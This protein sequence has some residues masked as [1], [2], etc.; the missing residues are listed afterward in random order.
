MK[1]ICLDDLITFINFINN[2]EDVLWK[3][4]INPFCLTDLVN[5]GINQKK[6]RTLQLEDP[7]NSLSSTP[8]YLEERVKKLEEAVWPKNIDYGS[9][10]YSHSNSMATA[11]KEIDFESRGEAIHTLER[12]R[13]KIQKFGYITIANYYYI[14]GKPEYI[15]YKLFDYGWTNLNNV[16]VYSYLKKG[17]SRVYCLTLPDP[18]PIVKLD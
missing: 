1:Y 10:D 2:D 17:G 11:V 6:V 13:D 16:A 5:D 3:K 4:G 14:S 9:Y 18:I 7:T 8:D 12:M 15:S